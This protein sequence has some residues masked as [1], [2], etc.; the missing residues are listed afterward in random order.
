MPQRDQASRDHQGGW[1]GWCLITSVLGSETS[2]TMRPILVSERLQC[3]SGHRRTV[4]KMWVLE[5][6]LELARG[7]EGMLVTK[8]MDPAL[9][10]LLP[11]W[12]P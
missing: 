4:D 2:L 7:R 5:D 12:G 3:G 9:S 10:R 11:V 6:T 1:E 8:K